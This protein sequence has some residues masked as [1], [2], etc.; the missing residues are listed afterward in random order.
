MLEQ[1]NIIL[2]GSLVS[3]LR[4]DI[5]D[6]FAV[7]NIHTPKDAPQGTIIFQGQLL[8]SDSE[9]VYDTIAQ[10]W[11]GHDYT[12]MLRRGKAGIELVAHPGVVRPKPSNPWINL[13][14]FIVTLISVLTISALNEGVDLLQDPLGV[15]KGFPFAFSFLAI[16]GAHEFGHYFLARYHQVAVTLPYF[17]PF[18]TIWGTFGA[19][20]QLRSPTITR[21]QLF[22]VGVAGPLAGLVVAIPV[23]IIGLLNS[24]I[25]PLPVEEVY[26]LEGNSIFYWLTKLII[27]GQPLPGNG[28]DVF[29]HPLAW[30]GWSGLLVTAFNLFPVGQLDGGHV[31]Y[32]IFGRAMRIIGYVVVAIMVVMGFFWQGWFFWALL[33]FLV[34][35]VGHPPPLN[36]LAPLGTGRKLLGYAMIL[37]FI[38][39]FVPAPLT[40]VGA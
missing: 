31:A 27:F 39:L 33:V 17:I 36:D 37:I 15:V 3:K 38:L 12:P 24:T 23:L 6:V 16:L 8:V 7:A 35:G 20:I 2:D 13:I 25:E 11:R 22:D 19:F 40:I 32:V 9:Y 30:A 10:R 14:L 1:A 29:L 28:V 34:I 26:M 21:R 4:A 18:P 5:E